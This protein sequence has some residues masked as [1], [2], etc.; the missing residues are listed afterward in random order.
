MFNN[1]LTARLSV[2]IPFP[3]FYESLYSSEIDNWIE[4]EAES[5][6]EEDKT[7]FAPE[8]CIPAAEYNTM[9]SDAMDYRA[10]CAAVGES[11]VD[12]YATV[13]GEAMGVKLAFQFEEMTSP[14]FY[15]FA[16]DRLFASLSYMTVLRMFAVSK[17]DGHKSLAAVIK[18]RFTSYDGFSSHYDNDLESWLDKP[19]ANWDHN[20]LGTLMIAAHK[21][22]PDYDDDSKWSI[23]YAVTEDGIYQECGGA[24]DYNKFETA[25]TEARD[26]LHAEMAELDPDYVPPAVRCSETP[27]LFKG[28]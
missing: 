4:Q 6:H 3:G 26:E 11:Y 19:L 24:T 12:A 15:N 22:S 13:I 5:Y 16:T 23:Y 18:D 21:A 27:D 20:E 8:L 28:N 25:V 14:K 7:K 10:A 9:L 1:D 2:N 17:R